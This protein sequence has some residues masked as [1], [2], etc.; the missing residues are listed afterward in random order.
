LWEAL[1]VFH[2]RCAQFASRKR[3]VQSNRQPTRF[4]STSA[5]RMSHKHVDLFKNR[6]R[7][8]KE[9]T[10][11]WRCSHTAARSLEHGD[12]HP[13]LKLTNATAKR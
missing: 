3:C 11:G 7:F 8:A 4:A 1:S 2:Q 6:A 12:S 13:L 9:V 10:A 5:V